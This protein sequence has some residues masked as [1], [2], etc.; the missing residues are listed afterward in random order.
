M[1]PLRLSV[2]S[3]MSSLVLGLALTVDTGA[4]GVAAASSVATLVL[5]VGLAGGWPLAV[6]IGSTLATVAVVG[7]ATAGASTAAVVASGPL[8]WVLV[9]AAWRSHELRPAVEV[10]GLTAATGQ[11]AARAWIGR[12]L[13]PALTAL[14]AGFLVVPFA[15]GVPSGGLAFRVLGLGVVV[16]VAGAVV[17]LDLRPG[18]WSRPR[19]RA[20]E[21]DSPGRVARAV[22]DPPP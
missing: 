13:A 22:A 7:A 3:V 19:M 2:M 4:V 9:E 20:R 14:A 10:P 17:I 16:T 18:R 15:H 8:L 11:A 6:L 12:L 5:T 1:N 21:P